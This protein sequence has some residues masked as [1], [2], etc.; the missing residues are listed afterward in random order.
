MVE[1]MTTTSDADAAALADYG[2]SI[3]S[4]EP[5][6]VERIPLGERHG[7]PSQLLWTWSS[8]NLEFATIYVGVIAVAFF[9][10]S[11][12]QAV[13]A[14]VIGNALGGLTQGVLSS[15]GPRHGL[16]QMVISRSAFGYWGNLLPAGFLAVTAGIG[17]FAVNSVSATLALNVL[18]GW[19]KVLCLVIVVLAQV[20]VA[21]FGHNLVHSFERWA[22][23]VLAVIFVIS[24]VVILSKS[25][26]GAAASPA[27]IP[28]VGAFGGFTLTVATVVGYGSGWNPYASDYTRYLAPGSSRRAVG[29]WAGAGIF[30]SC[31]VL[32]I[33]GAASITIGKA[34]SENPTAAFTDW[35]PSVIANL[36]LLAIAVGGVSANIL[37][38]YSGS[39]S[40]LTMGVRLPAHLRR[41]LVA[42][43]FGVIGF[44]VAIFGLDDAGEKY[45]T[46]LLVIGYWIAPW[47]GVVL[48][49]IWLRR[50]DR[51]GEVLGTELYDTKYANWA[52]PIAMVVGVVVSIGLFSNQT[53]F[54]GLVV[55]HAGSVGDLTPIVGFI[56]A[57]LIYAAI[58][59]PAARRRPTLV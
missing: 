1:R 23:P 11:F 9:G 47:L 55:R 31:I 49:D 5:G 57:A 48:V 27:L 26:P 35:M 58:R 44:L 10:L 53:K 41:A 33:V 2:D 25:H 17:W 45:E 40:F 12:W 13:L 43:T 38:I 37:N 46:F 8:P 16:P 14:L 21:F 18:T 6:G 24:S 20:V 4:V 28:G 36:T 22:F 59:I 52:G 32:Q 30:V 19:P 54:S 3:T 7:R 15:W 29:F 51:D 50:R 42:T 56:L 34:S 39:M